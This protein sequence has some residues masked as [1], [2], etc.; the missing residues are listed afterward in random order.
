MLRRI[1]S[2]GRK[3]ITRLVKL[4]PGFENDKVAVTVSFPDISR[5]SDFLECQIFIRCSDRFKAQTI[6][7]TLLSDF[8][9]TETYVF[10]E[11][12]KDD[13]P[14]V[15]VRL[16]DPASKRI[17]ADTDERNLVDETTGKRSLIITRETKDL[18]NELFRV[19]WREGTRRPVLVLNNSAHGDI[20]TKLLRD[21]AFALLVKPAV[22]RSVLSI[23]FT[24]QLHTNEDSSRH[25]Y[26]EKWLNV[27][28]IKKWTTQPPPQGGIN[29]IQDSNNWI[30]E[31][32]NTYALRL[33]LPERWNPSLVA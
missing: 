8:G 11:F 32:V 27:C 4:A 14:S 12:R 10:E 15:Q 13:D 28:K 6:P 16:V 30:D 24:E 18:K 5:L 1:R 29:W 26:A 23:I 7:G 31:T 20:K 19:E 25:E 9:G 2:A 33:G 3:D 17:C 22:L 21:A